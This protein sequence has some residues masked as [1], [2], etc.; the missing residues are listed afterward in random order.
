MIFLGKKKQKLF[1]LK[2]TRPAGER[3]APAAL[4]QW[5]KADVI[6]GCE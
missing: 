2:K 3:P 1:F 4:P 6:Y 5:V